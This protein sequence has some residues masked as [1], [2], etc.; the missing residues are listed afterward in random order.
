MGQ[1]KILLKI[2]FQTN[3]LYKTSLKG[4]KFELW[5]EG[6]D[7]LYSIHFLREGAK[8]FP[9]IYLM[10]VVPQWEVFCSY[11]ISCIL[12]QSAVDMIN[13]MRVSAGCAAALQAADTPSTDIKMLTTII[14]PV[15][16]WYNPR[17]SPGPN[18]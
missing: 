12:A 10:S 14:H 18:L 5:S 17:S 8:I 6:L 11:N 7:L 9:L 13:A 15:M 16:L 2:G 1:A 3:S 4:F